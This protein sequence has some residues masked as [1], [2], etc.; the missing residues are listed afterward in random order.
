MGRPLAC[1]W[2]RV[3][4]YRRASLGRSSAVVSEEVKSDSRGVRWLWEQKGSLGSCG[5]K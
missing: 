2:A 1:E 4:T 5:Y 3:C